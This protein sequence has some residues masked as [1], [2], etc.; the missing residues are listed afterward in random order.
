MLG[1]SRNDIVLDFIVVEH[2]KE[3]SIKDEKY[4]DAISCILNII[5]AKI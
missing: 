2:R 4:V 1:G 3:R 5:L